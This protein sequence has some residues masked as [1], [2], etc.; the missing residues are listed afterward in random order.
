MKAAAPVCAHQ[1]ALLNRAPASRR[2]GQSDHQAPPHTSV[3]YLFRR[4]E[5]ASS[6]EATVLN[7]LSSEPLLKSV[8]TVLAA[9]VILILA[10]RVWDVWGQLDASARTLRVIDTSGQAFKVL[11]NIRTDCNSVLRLWNV[12]DP[13]TPGMKTYLTQIE[14]AQMPALRATVEQVARLDFTG[15]DAEPA[16][17]RAS[18]ATLTAL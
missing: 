5:A 11:V 14:D 7:R 9:L 8:L 13:I 4:M 1:A 17:L 16:I 18:L 12:P 15:R 10:T 3:V 2:S 6:R